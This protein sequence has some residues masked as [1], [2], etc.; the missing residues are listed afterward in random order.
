MRI[1][2]KD[3]MRWIANDETGR[4]HLT[5]I[6]YAYEE[7]DTQG[8]RIAT[9]SEDFTPQRLRAQT[10]RGYIWTWDGEKR[11]KGGNRWFDNRGYYRIRKSDRKEFIE[12]I[13]RVY[14]VEV[15]E[16]RTI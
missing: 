15:A 8:K 13:K 12:M 3:L 6:E 14:G 11:N 7:L 9:G 4:E 16:F 10:I 2:G 1:Y 5:Q